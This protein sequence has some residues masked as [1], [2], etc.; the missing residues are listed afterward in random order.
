[1]VNMEKDQLI[2]EAIQHIERS[3]TL[4]DDIIKESQKNVNLM[5]HLLDRKDA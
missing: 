5:K 3:I 4:L 2:K 1:M